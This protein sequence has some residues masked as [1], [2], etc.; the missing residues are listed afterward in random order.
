[1]GMFGNDGWLMNLATNRQQAP[2]FGQA[3]DAMQMATQP[4]PSLAGPVAQ[5]PTDPRIDKAMHPGFFGKGGM[6]GKMLM[7]ALGG[8]LD[9]VA[10][11]GGAQPGYA[12]AMQRQAEEKQ[13]LQRMQAEREQRMAE[14]KARMENDSITPQIVN[15]GHG[16]IATATPSGTVNV[17]RQPEAD[18]PDY[19]PYANLFGERGTPQWLKAAQDYV[20][21]GGGPTSMA[22]RTDLKQ[23]VPG[24]APSAG[25]GSGGG[26]GIHGRTKSN[27][28][29]VNSKEALLAV[30]PGTWVSLPNGTVTQRR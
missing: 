1:M 17:L 26:M 5:L 18:I 16:G 24:K 12:M 30:P 27:P 8:A 15:L 22:L 20:L 13:W 28:I 3:P 14:L 29:P 10:Q 9:G 6:G 25:G 4:N 11:W 2:Q 21:R 23:T 7:G 19:E